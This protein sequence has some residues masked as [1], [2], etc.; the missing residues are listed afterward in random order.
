MPYD[1]FCANDAADRWA[2]RA[3]AD[4]QV[5]GAGVDYI[6]ATAWIIQDRLVTVYQ[7]YAEHG[8]SQGREIVRPAR[9]NAIEA[10]E[11]LGHIVVEEEDLH[12]CSICCSTWKPAR[13]WAVVKLGR[14]PGKVQVTYRIG[15]SGTECCIKHDAL[16][17][18]GRAIH[19]S[20]RLAWREGLL[21]CSKCGYYSTGVVRKLAQRCPLRLQTPHRNGC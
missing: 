1:F 14:C 12:Y 5:P 18:N 10:L 13:A 20:H 19:A 17:I 7:H 16:H 2:N 15:A 9:G 6:D 3:A 21:Y 8:K 4:V 11:E